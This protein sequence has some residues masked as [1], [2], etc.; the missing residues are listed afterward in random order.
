MEAVVARLWARE[1]AVRPVVEEEAA[2]VVVVVAEVLEV[3]GIVTNGCLFEAVV[4]SWADKMVA[5][6]VVLAV[7]VECYY[8][9]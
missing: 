6:E 5:V 8:C 2:A 3:L 7:V 9:C 4:V 1:R